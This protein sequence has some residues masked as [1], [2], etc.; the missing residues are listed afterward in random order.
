MEIRLLPDNKYIKKRF[1]GKIEDLV[2]SLDLRPD[3]VLVLKENRPVP[4]DD[5]VKDDDRITLIRVA[6]GG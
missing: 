1:R 4:I 3:E 6:S 2:R 5:E